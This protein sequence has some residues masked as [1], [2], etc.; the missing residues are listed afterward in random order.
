MI[1][2]M[3]TSIYRGFSQL[4]TYICPMIFP[5]FSQSFPGFCPIGHGSPEGGPGDPRL[6]QKAASEASSAAKVAQS[7]AE[8]CGSLVA[9]M[10]VSLRKMLIFGGF[11]DEW[12]IFHFKKKG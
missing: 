3:K 11:K 12:I 7:E 9:S 5:C 1:S 10:M 2:P 8:E 6:V 4:E